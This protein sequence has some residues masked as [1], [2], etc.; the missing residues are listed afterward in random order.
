MI[1]GLFLNRAILGS[2]GVHC[3]VHIAT[4]KLQ[5]FSTRPSS[6]PKVDLSCFPQKGA[7]IQTP[8]GKALIMRTP[9]IVE[10]IE[11]TVNH[12]QYIVYNTMNTIYDMQYGMAVRLKATARFQGCATQ[13]KQGPDTP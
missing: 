10:K 12:V 9:T 13:A 5:A 7:L 6:G 1:S 2:L 3:H 4:L 11:Y 8:S